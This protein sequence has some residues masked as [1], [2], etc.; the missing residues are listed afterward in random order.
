MEVNIAPQKVV[1]FGGKTYRYF[2]GT[3]YLGISQ[4]P[5]FRH[6]LQ[7]A[8]AV[9]GT[10]YGSSRIGN[11]GL[12][13]YGKLEKAL[14]K[15]FGSE[16]CVTFSS[17]FLAGMAASRAVSETYF[18]VRGKS[19]PA[20]APVGTEPFEGTYE[21]WRE[22]YAGKSY[23]EGKGYAFFSDSYDPFGLE[24]YDFGWFA[25]L[26]PNSDFFAV[27]DDSH[28]IGVYGPRGN[29]VL[30]KIP[31]AENLRTAIVASLNKA[32]GVPG[33]AVLCDKDL[34]ETIR[35]GD[36]YRTSSPLSPAYA[37]A[38]LACEDLYPRQRKSLQE[39]V[40]FF[41]RQI[42]G[43][44]HK[45]VHGMPMIGFDGGIELLEDMKQRGFLLSC[46]PYPEPTAQPNVRAVINAL[47]SFGDLTELAK[48]LK[49]S[50]AEKA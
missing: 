40:S 33:G 30:H 38:Y 20:L 14:A 24:E 9:Q 43:L 42:E 34:A 32:L 2:A 10:N 48:A 44:P 25:K 28:G 37:S 36:I 16:D 31:Q 5:K 46:F 11:I 6:E 26:T 23:T 13:V 47:H 3:S 19:H 8:F 12:A 49:L 41:L 39:N 18:P 50:L 4:H 35:H 1:E 27:I 21:E 22:T 17:G 45:M 29:G 7:H 15:R